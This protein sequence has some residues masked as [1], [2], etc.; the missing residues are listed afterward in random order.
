MVGWPVGPWKPGGGAGTV[1]V[2]AFVLVA[3]VATV[4]DAVAGWDGGPCVGEVPETVR[5]GVVEDD[6]RSAEIVVPTVDSR[7][8]C[9]R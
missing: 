9:V 2:A 8:V 3:A 6:A 1:L 7:A 5:V 4:L